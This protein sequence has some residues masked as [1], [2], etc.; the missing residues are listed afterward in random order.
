MLPIVGFLLA[1]LSLGIGVHR[2]FVILWVV[3]VVKAAQGQ[4]YE[5]PLIGPL[6]AGVRIH[7]A[8]PALRF[9]G[10]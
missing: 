5:L 10:T 1:W 4:H 7:R 2:A 3:L 8:Q 9:F 6:V